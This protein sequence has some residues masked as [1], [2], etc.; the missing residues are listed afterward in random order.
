MSTKSQLKRLQPATS[1]QEKPI[2][3]FDDLINHPLYGSSIITPGQHERLKPYRQKWEN[4]TFTFEGAG[5][6]LYAVQDILF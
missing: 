6:D 3:S 2:K 4:E 5:S 1:K